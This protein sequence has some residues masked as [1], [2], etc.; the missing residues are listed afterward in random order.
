MIKKPERLAFLLSYKLS[1]L[2]SIASKAH[3]YYYEDKEPKTDDDG[4]VRKENGDIVYRILHPSRGVLKH[5]QKRIQKVIFRELEFP[6]NIQGGIK[7]KSNITNAELHKGHKYFL[8]TDLSKYYPSV[9]HELVFNA[10]VDN[11][12]SH[13]VSHLLTRLTTY[14]YSLPQGTHTSPYL[15]NLVFSKYDEQLT[16]LCED[17]GLTY[18]R[19]VDDI[20]ISGKHDFKNE[21]TG[22]LEVIHSSP[23][24]I[25]HQKTFYKIGP[26]VVTGIVT[27]NNE[28]A[29]REDQIEKLTDATLNEASKKGLLEYIQ[30][31]RNS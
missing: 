17:K 13:D 5:I 9:G 19:Y 24:K 28:L 4:N 11:G 23:F 22:I 8:C 3:E 25:N 7:G 20:V 1:K 14:K 12:F 30:Q 21:I 6:D 2:K 10:L 31:V 29:P 15:A 16:K 27:K 18:S 26:T